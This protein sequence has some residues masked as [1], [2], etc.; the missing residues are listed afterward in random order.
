MFEADTPSVSASQPQVGDARFRVARRVAAASTIGIGLLIG[1]LLI[2]NPSQSPQVPLAEESTLNDGDD[3]GFL[4]R[5]IPVD[6]TN[7][8]DDVAVSDANAV[9][10]DQ[11][12]L[13]LDIRATRTC[14]VSAVADAERVAYRLMKAGDR[15]VVTAHKSITLRI[16]DAS[17]IDYSING[18][19]GRRLGGP[20]EV[21]TVRF[22]PGNV[23]LYTEPGS[24]F[25]RERE[26]SRVRPDPRRRGPETNHRRVTSRLLVG[27]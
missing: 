8:D 22:T 12:S 1:G 6:V 9:A 17:A 10:A 27:G 24:E 3:P 2:S 11:P 19:T 20:G 13:Q 18:A 15:E 7:G 4:E 23:E 16:G 25:P 14:W 26:A 21:I 5:A